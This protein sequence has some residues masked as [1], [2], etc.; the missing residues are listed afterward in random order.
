VRADRASGRG[1]GVCGGAG[2]PA[3]SLVRR[4]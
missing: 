3:P 4:R 1:L 2:R